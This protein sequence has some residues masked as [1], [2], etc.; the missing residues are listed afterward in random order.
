MKTNFL[1]RKCLAANMVK[2]WELA[3]LLNVSEM[4]LTRKFRTELPIDEQKRICKLI[5][6][7]AEK[8]GQDHERVHCEAAT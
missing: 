4:T 7:Y 3:K 2:H 6:E 8:R 1:I 5:E